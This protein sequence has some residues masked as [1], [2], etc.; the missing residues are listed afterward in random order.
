MRVIRIRAVA[1]GMPP[2]VNEFDTQLA[3]EAYSLSK[4][5]HTADVMGIGGAA[6]SSAKAGQ[7]SGWSAKQVDFC[8]QVSSNLKS[9][10]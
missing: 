8:K 2:K 10:N 9:F 5:W 4:A 7:L 1:A 6:P 3:E